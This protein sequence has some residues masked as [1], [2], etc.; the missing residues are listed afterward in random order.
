MSDRIV[1]T[2]EDG[3][4]RVWELTEINGKLKVSQ[5]RLGTNEQ[6]LKSSIHV[7]LP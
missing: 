7:K 1:S 4:F 6:I 2:G 5:E 3:F